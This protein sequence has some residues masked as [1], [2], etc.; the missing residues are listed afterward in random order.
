MH[1]HI[2]QKRKKNALKRFRTLN[3][4]RLQ[5]FVSSPALL[6]SFA[7]PQLNPV[8]QKCFDDLKCGLGSFGM[9]CITVYLPYTR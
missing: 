7:R 3:L 2:N 8:L 9:D 6:C 5:M 1:I 4:K